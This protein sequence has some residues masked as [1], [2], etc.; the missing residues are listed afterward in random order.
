MLAHADSRLLC[1]LPWLLYIVPLAALYHTIAMA[2]R[3]MQPPLTL[4]CHVRIKLEENE[5]A[6]AATEATIERLHSS[7]VTDKGIRFNRYACHCCHSVSLWVTVLHSN[8]EQ[9]ELAK[10]EKRVASKRK[11]IKAITQG[12]EAVTSCHELSL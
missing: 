3:H 5:Q 1:N 9:S 8:Q 4:P 2:A 10:A 6:L 7:D 11:A 12:T